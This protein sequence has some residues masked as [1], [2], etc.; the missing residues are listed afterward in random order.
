MDLDAY[1]IAVLCWIDETLPAARGEQRLRQR[2]TAPIVYDRE[3]LTIEVVGAYLGPSQ[4]SALFDV[5]LGTANCLQPGYDAVCHDPSVSSGGIAMR[6]LDLYG[7]VDALWQQFEPLCE[8]ELV[9]AGTRRRKRATQL[10]SSA[11]MT[12]LI[13]FQPSGYRTFNGFYARHIRVHL[14]AAFPQLVSDTR[15]VALMP[16]GLLP[17]AV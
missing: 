17:L 1:M 10:G 14:S 5:R 4:D 15:C 8:R 3:V 16:R 11:I 12:I 7:S 13:L 9:A 6:P 2:G